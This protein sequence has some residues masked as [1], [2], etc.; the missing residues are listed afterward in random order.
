M[1][2]TICLN[3]KKAKKPEKNSQFSNPHLR[4]AFLAFVTIFFG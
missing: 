1:L 2:Q 4:M 3:E